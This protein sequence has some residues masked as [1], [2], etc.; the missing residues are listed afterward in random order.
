MGGSAVAR[1]RVA[2]ASLEVLGGDGS[3]ALATKLR[4][5]LVG[6]LEAAGFEVVPEQVVTELLRGNPGLARC[7]T[8]TCLRGFGAAVRVSRAVRARIE[9]VGSSSYVIQLELLATSDGSPTGHVDDQCQVCTVAEANEAVSNAARV[10][11]MRLQPR[12]EGTPRARQLDAE[13]AAAFTAGRYLDAARSFEEAYQISSQPKLLWNIAQSYRR[14]YQIDRDLAK[15]RRARL[16]LGNFIRVEPAGP[17]HNEAVALAAE[18]DA[19]LARGDQPGATPSPSPSP[20][21]STVSPTP[22]AIPG[23]APNAIVAQPEAARVPLHKRWQLW[24]GVGLG[25]AAIASVAIAVGV[26]QSGT[27]NLWNSATASCQAPCRTVDY[28]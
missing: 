14:Q 20:S 16:V 25:V 22:N 9:I 8:V 3:P 4:A 11:G 6:G 10:L 21:P 2:V 27:T 1:E 7:Q 28:R 13:G 17:D 5:S 12:I 24:L 26:T 18:L 15:L 19:E 23:A